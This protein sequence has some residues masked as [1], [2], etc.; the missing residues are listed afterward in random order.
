MCGCVLSAYPACQGSEFTCDNKRCVSQAMVCD[1]SDDC[2]D[3]SDEKNCGKWTWCTEWHKSI[4]SWQCSYNPPSYN[5]FCCE[6]KFLRNLCRTSLTA[7]WVRHRER[8]SREEGER[9]RTKWNE[10]CTYNIYY[11]FILYHL[12]IPVIKNKIKPTVFLCVHFDG[13]SCIQKSKG[14]II[15]H[16]WTIMLS[17]WVLNETTISKLANFNNACNVNLWI[18]SSNSQALFFQHA[19]WEWDR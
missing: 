5:V 14:I 12:I 18:F 8:E 16:K 4:T 6:K 17:F 11:I 9:E 15:C 3:G 2:N 10:L 19:V 13:L 7:K 1:G